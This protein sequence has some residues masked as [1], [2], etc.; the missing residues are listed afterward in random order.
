MPTSAEVQPVR[1][2]WL[3]AHFDRNGEFADYVVE[4]L[5]RYRSIGGD[6]VVSTTARLT[7]EARASAI[8]S[9]D[10]LIERPNVGLDFASWK[11]AIDS[12]SSLRQY[13]E[14]VIVNDS[15][16]GP[17]YSISNIFEKIRNNKI[18]VHGLT[19]NAEV[20][21]HIQSYFVVFNMRVFSWELFD[22]FWDEVRVLQDKREIILK[23]EIG[24]SDF[25]VANGFELSAAFNPLATNGRSRFW[26]WFCQ[27]LPSNIFDVSTWKLLFF[28]QL[29]RRSNP[30]IYHWFELL[31]CGVPFVKVELLRS[32]P[33]KAN[34]FPLRLCLAGRDKVYFAMIARHLR[35]CS[36]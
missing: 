19:I 24:L 36:R 3:F 29:R 17:L 18:P 31:D 16:Y 35:D 1:R 2:L 25:L 22:S 14:V 6:I 12:I 4:T 26:L 34:L 30:T 15:I 7:A 32:N 11:T 27:S 10:V 13:E 23:Y 20:R 21:P 28:T 33:A 9:S 8:A 5:R